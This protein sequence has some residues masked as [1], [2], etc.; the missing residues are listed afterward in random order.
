MLTA[1]TGLGAG[2]DRQKGIPSLGAGPRGHTS[3]WTD[4]GLTQSEVGRSQKGLGLRSHHRGGSSYQ[5]L[6][7]RRQG[8]G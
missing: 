7:E 2:E 8:S 3:G 4:Q 5:P 6:A 1:S